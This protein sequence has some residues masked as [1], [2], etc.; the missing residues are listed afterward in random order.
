MRIRRNSCLFL[1]GGIILYILLPSAKAQLPSAVLQNVYPPFGTAGSTVKVTIS[2]KNLESIDGLRFNDSTIQTAPETS[3]AKPPVYLKPRPVP[4][5][6]EIVIPPEVSP[7]IYEVRAV[8]RLGLSTARPFQ[9]L[10]AKINHRPE[11]SAHDTAEKA[12]PVKVGESVYG[13]IN[14]RNVKWFKLEAKK[15]ERYFMTVWAE[16]LDSRMDPQIRVFD[17]KNRELERAGDYF[18]RDPFLDFTAPS[19]GIYTIALADNLY[20]GGGN[21][22]FYRFAVHQDPHVDFIWPPAGLPGTKQKFTLFGRNLSG[23]QLVSNFELDGKAMESLQVEVNIPAEA[24]V[25]DSFHYETPRRAMLPGFEYRIGNS[26]AV[27][28]GFATAP[29]IEEA[30]A[31]KTMRVESVPVEIAGRFDQPGDYDVYRFFGEKDKDY[32]IEIYSDR[33]GVSA[34][35]V[36]SVKRVESGEKSTAVG[37]S[38]DLP[39]FFRIDNRDATHLDTRDAAYHLTAKESGEYEVLVLNQSSSGGPGHFY[40]L[41]IREATHDFELVCATEDLLTATNGRAGFPIA[42]VLRRNGTVAYRIAA[43][44]QDGFD[45][46]I[47]V[48][49]ESLPPGVTAKPL[50]LHNGNDNGFFVLQASPDVKRWSGPIR[51]LGKAKI[52]DREVVRTAR[53]ASLVWGVIFADSVRVRTRLD[54]ETVLSVIQEESAP[55]AIEVAGGG[56]LTAELNGELEIPVK[57]TDFDKI[58]KG[59]LTVQPLGIQGMLRN[60]PSVAIAE[61]KSEGLLKIS[62]TPNGNFKA[63]PGKYDFVL[64]GTGI[65][66]HRSNLAALAKAGAELERLNELKSETSKRIDELKKPPSEESAEAEKQKQALAEAEKLIAEIDTALKSA[67]Q[68]KARA[69]KS[70]KETDTKFLARSEVITLTVTGPTEKK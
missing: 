23:G 6:F 36:I 22:Y 5:R 65:A 27:R 57:V 53:N 62:L 64:N 54:I 40:R 19:D 14:A 13:T 2:G 67:E 61:G 17:F 10:P 30:S 42:P 20:R 8:G 25:P 66:R 51:L 69:E 11:E 29:V 63:A 58:R 45:G 15:G 32:W 43:F 21:A 7:G 16:R 47:V 26:N 41:A 55:C 31:A 46:D 52:G 59:N 39:S 12:L 50:V 37:E 24:P 44:R 68:E 48:S 60:E 49:A 33:L 56:P 1:I 35:P 34:D 3:P 70:A 38:D 28:I 18:G 9:V 4:N